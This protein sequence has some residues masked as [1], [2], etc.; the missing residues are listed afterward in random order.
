MPVHKI[1]IVDDSRTVQQ[2]L[3]EL[4]RGQGYQVATC[5]SAEQAMVS[6]A[7]DRPDLLLLDV[8]MP[9][10]KNGFQFTRA[11]TRDPQYAGLPIILC[12]NKKEETDRLWGMRQGAREYIIK[13]VQPDELLA[14]IRSI[15]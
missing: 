6:L 1:L 5:D 4:L 11:I 13:P 10:G 14:K 2:Q 12:S 15:G 3:S 8:V 7:E 9:G